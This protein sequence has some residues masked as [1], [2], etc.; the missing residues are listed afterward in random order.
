[1]LS[2]HDAWLSIYCLIECSFSFRTEP[3]G[4]LV[5]PKLSQA[6]KIVAS[7]RMHLQFMFHVIIIRDLY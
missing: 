4:S 2:L 7:P 1:M 3:S 6:P 5:G